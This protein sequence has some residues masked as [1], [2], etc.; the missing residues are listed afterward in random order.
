MLREKSK[1]CQQ[2]KASLGGEGEE[3]KSA[4]TGHSTT[5]NLADNCYYHQKKTTEKKKRVVPS[6]FLTVTTETLTVYKTVNSPF[7]CL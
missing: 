5:V 1:D 6:V 2:I 4:D 7:N 3:D